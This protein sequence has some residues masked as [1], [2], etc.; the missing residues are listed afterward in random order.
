MIKGSPTI[1][2]KVIVAAVIALL[3]FAKQ[4]AFLLV[5][6]NRYF[7]LWK[8]IDSIGVILDVLILAVIAF[9]ISLLLKPRKLDM[10]RRAYNHLFLLALFSGVLTLMPTKIINP[11]EASNKAYLIWA[12]I[13]GV[14]IWS[15]FKKGSRLVEYGANAC[16]LFSPIVPILLFQMYSTGTWSDLDEVDSSR[17]QSIAKVAGAK[18]L[19]TSATPVAQ[20]KHPIFIFV[21]DEWS[22]KF[23]EDNGTFLDK[24]PHIKALSQ[25]SYSFRSA[26]SYSSRSYHSLPAIIYQ[27]DQRLEP[28]KAELNWTVD[29]KEISTHDYDSLLGKARKVGYTTA[30]QGFYLPYK[31]IL[32]PQADYARSNSVFAVGNDLMDSMKLSALRNLEWVSEPITSGKRRKLEAGVQSVRWYEVNTQILDETL[33]MIDEAPHNTCAFFHW[34]T[35]HGPFILNADGSYHGQYPSGGFL[36][37]LHGTVEDY[38]RHLQNLDRVIGQITDHLKA[39]GLYDDAL[40]IMTADHGWRSDPTAH[41]NN[42]KIDPQLRK[43][44]MLVKLPGQKAAHFEDTIVYNNVHLQPIVEGVLKNDLSEATWAKTVS[45]FEKVPIPT[46]KNSTRVRGGEGRPQTQDSPTSG[47]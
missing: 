17:P 10:V 21:F 34:P 16:I 14:V 22:A 39:K 7:Y 9:G 19:P 30:I 47:F 5:E 42:W 46:G 11:F 15:F 26:W 44:P 31:R 37:G 20:T 24:Y 2:Q 25:Q 4:I 27:M 23:T 36:K 18:N 12:V 35:P 40:V 32:G 1:S 29:G 13:Y 6:E 45:T 41:I 3:T 28:K 43:V 33:K 8:K 38:E